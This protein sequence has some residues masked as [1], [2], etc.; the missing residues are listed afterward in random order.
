MKHFF[1]ITALAYF[2]IQISVVLSCKHEPIFDN[3]PDPVD[4]T[5]NPV[6]TGT[7]NPGDTS[8]SGT[9]CDPNTV[10]FNTQILPVLISNCAFSGCHDAAT[11]S[12]GVVLTDFNNVVRTADVEAG[13]LD[14]D[15]YEVITEDKQ[16]KRMPQFPR[17]RLTAEQIQLIRTWIMQGAQ[18]LI[19]DQNAG[20]CNTEATTYSGTIRP[21]LQNTCVGCHRDGLEN[22]GINLS[23]HAGV[24][25]AAQSGR[26]YGAINRD[27]GFVAMPFGGNKLQQCS[28]ER[29]KYWIDAGAPDN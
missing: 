4:S 28:I 22:G 23:S 20:G 24:K 18:N 8:T 5:G 6:D 19:C 25:A 3:L 9:P 2:L 11:A 10:Y 16:D 14:S 7:M 29:I 27:P 26:L 12:D 15:L 17:P 21:L 1:K 13:D